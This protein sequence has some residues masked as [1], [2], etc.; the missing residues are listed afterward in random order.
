LNGSPKSPAANPVIAESPAPTSNPATKPA[1]TTRGVQSWDDIT[2]A[3]IDSITYDDL[4]V[5]GGTI[6]PV[7]GE[8]NALTDVEM[9][10]LESIVA[11]VGRWP[12]ARSVDFGQRVRAVLNVCS[13]YDL[14]ADPLEGFVAFELFQ[15]LQDR[16]PKD[17]LAQVLTWIILNP[18]EGK[19][20]TS[21]PD[22]DVTYQAKE[23]EVRARS[24]LYAK[25][26][27]LR[28]LKKQPPA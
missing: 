12:P 16:I 10:R 19:V 8:L 23:D 27:L 20:A 4:P 1:A 6:V 25:K 26:L 11:D 9:Q 15:K 3:Q 5:D 21:L 2:P 17:R 28:V 24:A 22:F 7:V 13:I 14:A 18:D